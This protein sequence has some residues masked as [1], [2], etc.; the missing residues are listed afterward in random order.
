MNPHGNMDLTIVL[1]LVVV[2]LVAVAACV[3]VPLVFRRRL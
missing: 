2:I 1:L 3:L